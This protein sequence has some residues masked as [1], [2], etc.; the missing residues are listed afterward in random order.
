MNLEWREDE[1]RM[2]SATAEPLRYV[3][4]GVASLSSDAPGWSSSSS[5]TDK[6]PT[7]W[8]CRGAC[9][10]L[11]RKKKRI[12]VPPPG[13]TTDDTTTKDADNVNI[14]NQRQCP[15]CHGIGH[16]PIKVKYLQS[17]NTLGGVITSRRRRPL[18][19]KEFGHIPPAIQAMLDREWTKNGI[20]DTN[21]SMDGNEYSSESISESS[22]MYHHAALYLLYP[23]SG[24]WSG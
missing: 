20:I 10:L 1:D 7:C 21:T 18:G 5:A 19:W 11:T 4:Q 17:Q 8:K 23:I 14:I 3:P 15:I 16:L 6:G 24:Q 12:V 13:S 9:F 2:N 22:E